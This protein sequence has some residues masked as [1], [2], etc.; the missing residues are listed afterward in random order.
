MTT[1]CPS[2]SCQD[3]STSGVI[4]SRVIII[5]VFTWKLIKFSFCITKKV[6]LQMMEHSYCS[7]HIKLISCLIQRQPRLNLTSAS[8]LVLQF[9]ELQLY[10]VSH[11]IFHFTL[12]NQGISF[13]CS[14][15]S[16]LHF[17][18]FLIFF[19]GGYYCCF[20]TDTWLIITIWTLAKM[21]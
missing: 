4:L 11:Q 6:C 10:A 3:F 13:K 2:G 19:S 15:N 7:F 20:I 17:L 14:K 1:Y 5:R 12:F 9:T 21:R 16:K 18:L 8:S